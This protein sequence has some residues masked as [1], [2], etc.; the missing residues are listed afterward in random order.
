VKTQLLDEVKGRKTFVAVFDTGDEPIEAL[1]DFAK[2][3]RLSGAHLSG[4]GAFSTVTLGFFDSFTRDYVRIPIAEQ[5]EVVS[6]VGNIVLHEGQ[7]KVH[8][9]VVVARRDGTALGGHLLEARVSPTLEVVIDDSRQRLRRRFDETSGL[10][11]IDL[12]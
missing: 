2:Q 11:L 7:P 9:H 4:I 1:T 6:L 10:A 8:A 5:V 12:G 3:E